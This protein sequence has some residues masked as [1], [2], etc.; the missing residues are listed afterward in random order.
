V[1]AQSCALAPTGAAYIRVA[2]GTWQGIAVPGPWKLVPRPSSPLAAYSHTETGMQRT[3]YSSNTTYRHRPQ[4]P[5]H[6]T[7][8]ATHWCTCSYSYP[9]DCG[10]HMHP[11]AYTPSSPPILG[12]TRKSFSSTTG[13]VVSPESGRACRKGFREVQRS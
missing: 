13:P 8:T 6:V 7:Y 4:D 1:C 12:E 5:C 11:S 9:V 2:K 10:A 3:R